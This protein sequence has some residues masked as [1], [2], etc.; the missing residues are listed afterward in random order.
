MHAYIPPLS[1]CRH[2]RR[3]F[4]LH[5]CKHTK[6]TLATRVQYTILYS[7]SRSKGVQPNVSCCANTRCM[8]RY[9]QSFQHTINIHT[10]IRKQLQTKIP[11][12]IIM[13]IT[14]YIKGRKSYT[15]YHILSTSIQNWRSTKWRPFTNTIQHLRCR[16]TTSSGHGLRR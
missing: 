15:I 9:E 3:A 6:H 8:T 5:N 10:L 7:N 16:H 14:N 1:N 11:G 13:F 4:F 12:T 2:W